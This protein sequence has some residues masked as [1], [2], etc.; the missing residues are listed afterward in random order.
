MNSHVP[1]MAHTST[2]LSAT[3]R[4]QF[5]VAVALDLVGLS[6]A[7]FSL[8]TISWLGLL[9][10]LA[11]LLCAAFMAI[12]LKPFIPKGDFVV[13]AL[14]VVLVGAIFLLGSGYASI[15]FLVYAHGT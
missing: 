13:V 10:A 6:Y 7:A 12:S 1:L 14:P 5:W 9:V 2:G 15:Q 11:P 4:V 3:R 8:W